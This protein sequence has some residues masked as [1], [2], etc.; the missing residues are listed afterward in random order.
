MS[1]DAFE[2]SRRNG[3][4]DVHYSYHELRATCA[5]FFLLY[6]QMVVHIEM[7]VSAVTGQ[8]CRIVNIQCRRLTHSVH[9]CCMPS[10]ISDLRA[11]W[12]DQ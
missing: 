5:H 3:H 10:D 2:A 4:S 11:L 1:V 7:S 6:I 12:V 8:E 9:G